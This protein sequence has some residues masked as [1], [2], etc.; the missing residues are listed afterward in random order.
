MQPYGQ[1]QMPM[2][3]QQAIGQ[4]QPALVD[5]QK[6]STIT[7]PEQRRQEIGNGIYPVIQQTYGQ[8]ASKITGMLLDNDQ[9]VDPLKLVTDIN[10]LNQKAFEAH[11]LL[12]ENILQQQQQMTPDQ[13]A[14]QAAQAE[15]A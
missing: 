5:L 1:Q 8:S 13:I 12:Q 7:E 3:G 4:Q 15:A 14:A 2:G 11:T 10:Y 6:L 9:V